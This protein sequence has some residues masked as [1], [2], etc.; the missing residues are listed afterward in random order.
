MYIKKDFLSLKTIEL[1]DYT[2]MGF[3]VVPDLPDN[4][5]VVDVDRDWR[6]L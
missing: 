6:Y 2:A 3:S 1:T 4:V 5:S